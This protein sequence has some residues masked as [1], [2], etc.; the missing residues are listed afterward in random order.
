MEVEPSAELGAEAE[1]G[2]GGRL[3]KTMTSS[4]VGEGRSAYES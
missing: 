3:A 1:G 2:D 4:P